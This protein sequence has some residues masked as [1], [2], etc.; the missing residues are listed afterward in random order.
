[1]MLMGLAWLGQTAQV[2]PFEDE[3][4]KLCFGQE[5]THKA[6]LLIQPEDNLELQTSFKTWGEANGEE[7]VAFIY[8]VQ[9]D[10]YYERVKDF[11]GVGDSE[12]VMIYDPES[13]HKYMLDGAIT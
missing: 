13:R 12:S 4:V 10:Q 6:V 1:M 5:A 11:L 2:L 9:S 3:A 8:L 7:G